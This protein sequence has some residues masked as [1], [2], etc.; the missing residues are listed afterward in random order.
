LIDGD[1]FRKKRKSSAGGVVF[2]LSSV[3]LKT[4]AAKGEL[5]ASDFKIFAFESVVLVLMQRAG[6]GA[7]RGGVEG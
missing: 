4:F 5:L 2:E 7:V 6:D 3:E 1:E